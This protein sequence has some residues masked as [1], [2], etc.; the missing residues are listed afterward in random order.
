MDNN[1]ENRILRMLLQPSLHL[2]SILNSIDEKTKNILL[3]YLVN[4]DIEGV[5]NVI[6]AIISDLSESN[7]PFDTDVLTL[8]MQLRLFSNELV[9][10][11]NNMLDL[12]YHKESNDAKNV[13]GI[14]FDNLKKHGVTN[15]VEIGNSIFEQIISTKK[16]SDK[17]VK[18]EMS[19]EE[20][21]NLHLT[22]R[23]IKKSSF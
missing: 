11:Y 10:N 2:Y 8:Q 19:V 21:F 20:V 22:K 15:Y 12:Q 9:E 4:E 3:D 23:K 16:S 7:K 13:I 1:K 17:V 6:N 5:V 14:V 18:K